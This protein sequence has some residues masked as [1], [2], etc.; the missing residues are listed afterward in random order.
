MFINFSEAQLVALTPIRASDQSRSM[1][2]GAAD[3]SRSPQP[4]HIVIFPWLAFGHLLPG[5]KLARRLASRG[6]RVS[7]VSTPRNLSRLPPGLAPRVDLVPLPLP[8]VDGLPEGA[9]STNDVPYE[10]FGLHRKAFDGLAAPFAACAD[11]EESRPDWVLLDG[12]H[13]WAAAAA[14]D[15]KVAPGVL[16]SLE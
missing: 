10:K 13:H 12:F 8:R 2:D 5:L 3:S 14:V 11:G 4:M 9:E 7:F 16:L 1:D 6:H 15:R